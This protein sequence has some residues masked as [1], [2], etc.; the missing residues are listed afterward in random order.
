M[1]VLKHEPNQYFINKNSKKKILEIP[2]PSN[3]NFKVPLWHTIGF[4][5]GFNYLKKQILN[6][7]DTNNFFNYV[8][9]PADF[10]IK[11]DL[12]VRYNNSL[13]RLNNNEKKFKISNLESIISIAKSK[14]YTFIKM[15]DYYNYLNKINTL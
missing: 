12:D 15:N 4:M 2:M 11:N 6:Y 8:I 9:H 1:L 10:L 14:N 13:P 5:F 3:N 7:L